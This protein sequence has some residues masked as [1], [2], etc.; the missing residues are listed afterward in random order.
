MIGASVVTGTSGK[1]D[2]VTTRVEVT[3][4]VTTKAEAVWTLV[5]T[6]VE[7]KEVTGVVVTVVVVVVVVV[8]VDETVVDGVSGVLCVDGT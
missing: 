8:V 1:N 2:F 6:R 4:L 5:K 3:L 7:G